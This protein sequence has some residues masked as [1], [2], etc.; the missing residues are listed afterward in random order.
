VQ[1]AEQIESG[2]DVIVVGGGSAGAV[3]A[4]RLS[5]DPDVRVLLLEAGPDYRSADAPAE[6]HG[7]WT[8][9]LDPDRFSQYHWPAL[10]A[11]R[12]HRR[13][14]DL[15]WRGRGVGGSSAINGQ[16]AIRPPLD[17][18]DDWVALG[19]SRWSASSVL[20]SFI[21]LEDDLAFGDQPWHGRGGPIP[22]SRAPLDEWGALDLAFRDA[23]CALGHAWAPDCNEPG[24]SGVSIFPF[25]GRDGRRVS[26]NDGYLEPARTRTNLRILGDALV[27]RVEFDRNRAVGVR[28][29]VGGEPVTF[30]GD[31]IVLSAGAIHSPAIL[32]RSGVGPAAL[33]HELGVT[34][35]AD[36]PVGEG[37]QEHPNVSFTFG[38]PA[39]M[40]SPVNG[41]HTNAC[42]RWTSGFAGT[43]TNDMM[44]IVTG[45][46]PG[47]PDVTSIGLW[48]N[49]SFSRGSLRI[50][51]TDPT[52]DPEIDMAMPDD[53]RDRARLRMAI[54]VAAEVLEHPSFR[55]LRTSDP[56]GFDGTPLDALRKSDGAEVDEWID[57]V[58][59][60]SAHASATCPLGRVVD[61]DCRVHGADN[62]RVIDLSIV[63]TVPRA[64]TNLTAIMIGEHAVAAMR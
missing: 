25:N 20:P 50:T 33:L 10:T 28:A 7:H 40:P 16:A 13:S 22:I 41:R 14:A 63:P 30:W 47:F 17:E 23:F 11:R 18:F 1:R 8:L 43:G 48:V 32:Q 38:V 46:R 4:S 62:L 54:D 29:L 27:D 61:G 51:S 53:S 35:L 39:D 52:I 24:A 60:G 42:V 56:A 26:T 12:G 31:E 3:V 59:D 55:A 34:V 19:G 6:M 64:N 57:R 9:I 2:Y 37:F 44:A 58:V 49:Q 45:T 21:R 15:Y 36:L 5:E